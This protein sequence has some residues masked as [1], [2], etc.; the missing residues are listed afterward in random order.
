M[1]RI[2]FSSYSYLYNKLHTKNADG[3]FCRPLSF[4]AHNQ[5]G[6]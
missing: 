1:Y 2:I 4:R 3:Y 5:L 6:V